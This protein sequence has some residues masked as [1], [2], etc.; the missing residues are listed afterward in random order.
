M[1]TIL[2]N[3]ETALDGV[4]RHFGE[5]L[6]TVR[7]NRPSVGLLEDIKVEYYGQF[8]PVKQLA[9]LSIRPPRD[10]E[11]SAWDK[12]AVPAIMKAIESMQTGLS[13]STDGGVIRVTLPTLSEERRQEF[14]KLVKKMAEADRIQV[15]SHREEAMKAL[16]ADESIP[17][18]QE[19]KGRERIQKL[20]DAANEK[21]EAVLDK[22]LQELAE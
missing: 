2:K 18:D 19:F 9:S 14:M 1:E 16:K 20:V 5:E 6:Q 12:G 11:V 21:I 4:I 17:E 15:R 13:A 22:K 7:S 3:L 8:M 10:I